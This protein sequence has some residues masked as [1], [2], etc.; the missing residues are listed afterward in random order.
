MDELEIHLDL[1]RENLARDFSGTPIFL[2]EQARRQNDLA[3]LDQVDDAD[4]VIRFPFDPRWRE[5][6]GCS[7]FV[8]LRRSRDGKRYA[9]IRS[10]SQR[11]QGRKGKAP[12][13]AE[14]P[15]IPYEEEDPVGARRGLAGAG[16]M[17]YLTGD[18]MH[19]PMVEDEY[20]WS[21]P[22]RWSEAARMHT[23][24]AVRL[25]APDPKDRVLDVGCGVGGP[26]RQLVD[27][28]GCEVYC[29]ANSSP[30]LETAASLNEKKP[31][32]RERISLTW[33]D[34]QEPFP[35]AG[36]D[37]AWS[38]NMIYR[39]PDQSAMLQ[40]VARALR[41]GGKMMIEDWMY[42]DLVTTADRQE[43]VHHFY[44]TGIVALADFEPQLKA[45]GFTVMA[46]EDLAHVGRTLMPRYF[47]PLFEEH[48]RPLLE[49][50]FPA[51]PGSKKVS[52]REMAE[53]WVSGI[54]LTNRLYLEEK[55]TYR[56]YLVERT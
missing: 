32:W 53:Q 8:R 54:E 15:L 51:S 42:T 27:E 52:G 56:R 45:A 14:I 49:A 35:E 29:V 37:A 24:A 7:Q 36:F 22:A 39:V 41:P 48:V 16:L 26:A 17:A 25:L 50:D 55:L 33:H 21:D 40:N 11:D 2:L 5:Q 18:Q 31:Q 10:T 3:L 12:L 46:A 43:M 44:G 20:L 30:M 47:V 13:P 4:V 6:L 19:P 28:A 38:M 23:R 34:A 1:S 9:L